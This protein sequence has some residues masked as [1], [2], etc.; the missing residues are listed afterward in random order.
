M[1]VVEADL[2][3]RNDC[4]QLAAAIVLAYHDLKRRDD[5]KALGF[6]LE[7]STFHS[8]RRRS[9]GTNTK[10][11]DRFFDTGLQQDRT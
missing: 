6:N 1:V 9:M 11:I 4:C 2:D 8:A 7:P 5:G 10:S 3:A